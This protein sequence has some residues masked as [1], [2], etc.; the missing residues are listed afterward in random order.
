[1]D[2]IDVGRERAELE[3]VLNSNLFRKAPNQSRFLRY[4][5][6]RYFDRQADQP[7]EHQIAIE[8]LGRNDSFDE[9]EDS[10]VRVEAF[11]LRRRLQRYY[12]DE[13]SAHPLRIAMDPGQY[14]VRFVEARECPAENISE[15]DLE[16]QMVPEA[17]PEQ[18]ARVWRHRIA[19]ILLVIA[20]AGVAITAALFWRTSRAAYRGSAPLGV[21]APM[22][23]ATAVNSGPAVRILAGYDRPAHLDRL[24][25]VW[26]GDKWFHGGEAVTCPRDFLA[27]TPDRTLY[28][29]CR[30]GNFSYDIPL[31]IAVYEVLRYFGPCVHPWTVDGSL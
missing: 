13:G 2:L 28:R 11:R 24:G 15:L 9:R 29:H 8:A 7:K 3:A 16:Q 18:P 19:L 1:V 23:Q 27:R 12:Q 10:I 14:R 6:E 21:E 26:I 25:H 30:R 31:P 20:T 22:D 17:S 5:C 4:L